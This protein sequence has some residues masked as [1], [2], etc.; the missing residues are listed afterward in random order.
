[1]TQS[2]HIAGRP[3][4]TL[5]FSGEKDH[6][7][8]PAHLSNAC[9]DKTNEILMIAGTL[10]L[11]WIA[12]TMVLCAIALHVS[13]T[14]RILL[15]AAGALLALVLVWVPSRKLA[16]P[17]AS[18][19]LLA[20]CALAV[21]TVIASCLL[22][23]LFFDVSGDGNEY[24]KTAVAALAGG[25][26]PLHGSV[27][28]WPTYE[29][30]YAED[31]VSIW[32]DHYAQGLWFVQ[33]CL[34]RVTHSI[35]MAQ[36]TTTIVACAVAF[37]LVAYLRYN[38]INS[39]PSV[40]I[41]IISTVN[42]ITVAQFHS[43]YNDG[44]LCLVLFSLLIALTMITD[45]S[46]LQYR[47]IT[48]VLAGCSFIT[49]VGTKFTGLAYAGVFTCA[50]CALYIWQWHCGEDGFSTTKTL[51]IGCFFIAILLTSLLTV[52][53]SS[54]C[55][56][57]IEHGTP[58]FPILGEGGR[59][60]IT[61]QQPPSFAHSSQL[62]K[63]VYGFF[64]AVDN[65]PYVDGIRAEP[66]L[67]LPLTVSEDELG[68]LYRTDVRLSGFGPLYSA[69]LLICIPSYLAALIW[70]WQ[71]HRRLLFRSTLVIGIAI[72]GLMVG[73]SDSWWARYSG[74]FYATNTIVLVFYAIL[75]E[76][77]RSQPSTHAPSRLYPTI[78]ALVY[79]FLLVANM[80]LWFIWGT[81]I[82]LHSAQQIWGDYAAIVKADQEG[83]LIEISYSWGP[84]PVYTLDD[85]SVNYTIVNRTSEFESPDGVL[86]SVSYRIVEP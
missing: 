55:T 19:R 80:A 59:D 12:S 24:H 62:R 74:Y 29:R 35:E 26:N 30:L 37:L 9:L 2:S 43:F 48:F 34:Y 75:I 66:H 3:P 76:E 42:P 7:V 53:W 44:F 46:F 71:R 64:S 77:T 31:T 28:T 17:I 83:K 40:F 63:L 14:P 72:L 50:F 18:P 85:L 54:Y 5:G 67:K 21:S 13:V 73:V 86:F 78:P 25:W 33:A 4:V 45:V 65:I 20:A 79:S 10:L 8:H 68:Y 32:I 11:T 57:L 56:N 51:G 22:A 52:G 39:L 61:S 49:C 41:A 58:F 16:H 82:N 70:S 38:G 6:T 60:I 27:T 36:A 1:M 84:G 47:P 15:A 69:A 23:G 81:R